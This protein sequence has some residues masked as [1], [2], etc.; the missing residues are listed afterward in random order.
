MKPIDHSREKLI[1]AILYFVK[2]TQNCGK[3][4]TLKLLYFLDFIH[5]KEIGRSVTGL[6][7]YA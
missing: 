1:N 5:Y 6:E 4:K 2:N 3:L 7:Y